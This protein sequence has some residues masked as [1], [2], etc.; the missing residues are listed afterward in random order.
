MIN[1]PPQNREILFKLVPAG[2]VYQRPAA[3]Y[4]DTWEHHIA[5]F[6]QV[7]VDDIQNVVAAPSLIY[8]DKNQETRH[9]LMNND[10]ITPSG[11]KMTVFLETQTTTEYNHIATAFYNRNPNVGPLLFDLTNT[12]V[13]KSEG[14]LPAGP[15]LRSSYDDSNDILYLGV[16][17]A[18]SVEDEEIE[19]GV[20]VGY[21]EGADRPRA[22][23]VFGIRERNSVQRDHVI[24]LLANALRIRQ[25]QVRQE[26]EKAY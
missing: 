24:E 3:L 22:A 6:K 7:A 26:F 8:R 21:P 14:V 1:L 11:T 5:P 17:D 12:N 20:Y 18:K 9:V 19:D 10:V 25:S 15:T 2:N 23:V 13:G 16:D 4:K